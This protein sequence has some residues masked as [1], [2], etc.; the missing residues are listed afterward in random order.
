MNLLW[1]DIYMRRLGGVNLYLNIYMTG[2]S[3]LIPH[4]TTLMMSIDNPGPYLN[5]LMIAADIQA[6]LW[7]II[8]ITAQTLQERA[9]GT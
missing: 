3:V 4:G 8:M 1:R 5:S 6:T 7:T 2:L 9:L